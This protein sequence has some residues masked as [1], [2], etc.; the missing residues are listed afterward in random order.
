MPPPP[1]RT[2]ASPSTHTHTDR[3]TPCQADPAL[4]A[5]EEVADPLQR[6]KTITRAKRACS[7]C[8]VVRDCLKW[9]LANPSLTRRGV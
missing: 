3:P 8:P 2:N 7:G 5:F 9:A 4:F 1:P 6:N